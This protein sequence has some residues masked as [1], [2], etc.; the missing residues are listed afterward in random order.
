MGADRG[1]KDMLRGPRIMS[2]E[3]GLGHRTGFQS[4]SVS[5][6][7]ING[8]LA[9]LQEGAYGLLMDEDE[10]EEM[11]FLVSTKS[12]RRGT[13]TAHSGSLDVILAPPEATKG[14]HAL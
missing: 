13:P 4:S 2:E 6:R 5:P 11:Q 12:K 3:A 1:Q 10:L 9:D 7:L 14:T 8:L